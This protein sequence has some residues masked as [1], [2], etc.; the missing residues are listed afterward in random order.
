MKTRPSKIMFISIQPAPKI[1]F[2]FKQI[3]GKE[4]LYIFGSGVY[5]KH[6]H[7]RNLNREFRNL[8]DY[9]EIN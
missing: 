3:V 4:K 8:I 9:S 7:N 2:V 6:M 1:S 5:N